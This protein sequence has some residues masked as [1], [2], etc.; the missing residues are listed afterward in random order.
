[1]AKSHPAPMMPSVA[2]WLTLTPSGSGIDELQ[3][4]RAKLLSY[5]QGDAFKKLFSR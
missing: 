3:S 2:G 1:M 4:K 5:F